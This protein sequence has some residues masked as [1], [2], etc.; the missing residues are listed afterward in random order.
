MKK[1][2]EYDV[3]KHIIFS[4]DAHQLYTQV[5][6]KMVI[7]YV[8]TE[9]YKNPKSYFNEGNNTINEIEIEIDVPPKRILKNLMYDV[10]LNY[11]IFT[12]INH[13]YQ[14][15]EGL[16]MGSKLSGILANLYL[17]LMEREKNNETR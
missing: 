11:N 9:I 16:G 12:S 15:T 7:E 2:D 5:N 13:Y 14:Q 10:L 4:Y 3:D 8:V 17:W 6:T 1:S